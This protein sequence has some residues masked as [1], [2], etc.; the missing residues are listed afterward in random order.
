MKNLILVFV[1]L[2]VMACSKDDK[3]FDVP[4]YVPEEIQ[5]DNFR[6][7]REDFALLY[8]AMGNEA[9]DAGGI[10]IDKVECFENE[11][12]YTLSFSG[13][14]PNGNILQFVASTSAFLVSGE[15]FGYNVVLQSGLVLY[16]PL[17][18][19]GRLGCREY[20]GKL[21]VIC[22][23]SPIVIGADFGLGEGE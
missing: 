2:A 18:D 17:N 23:G 9:L 3:G 1:C 7:L 22:V 10:R 19:E 15:Y 12:G 4:A 13:N 6:V 8:K 11:G 20:N 5:A 16:T 21:Q 14:F